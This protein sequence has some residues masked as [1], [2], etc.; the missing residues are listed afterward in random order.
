SGVVVGS[1]GLVASRPAGSSLAPQPASTS[2]PTI[3]LVIAN[4]TMALTETTPSDVLK[5]PQQDVTTLLDEAKH[6][7]TTPDEQQESGG[8]PS[9]SCP[10]CCSVKH[11]W[12]ASC[13]ETGHRRCRLPR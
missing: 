3:A 1:A 4:L 2:E 10:A 13:W 9:P 6:R 8:L 7:K 5:K 11:R 12:P